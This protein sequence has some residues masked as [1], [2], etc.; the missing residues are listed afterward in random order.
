MTVFYQVFDS[1]KPADENG[2]PRLAGFG[3]ENSRWQNM[4]SARSYAQEWLGTT[5]QLPDDW[6]GSPID[7]SGYG[8]TIEIRKIE[9]ETRMEPMTFIQIEKCLDGIT[10]Y[11][12]TVVTVVGIGNQSDYKARF[13]GVGNDGHGDFCV[14]VRQ[15]DSF[16]VYG[17]HA[18]RIVR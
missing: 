9:E 15:E 2:F 10:K 1:G 4:L 3:W 5:C 16:M 6:D 12:D 18:S 14:Y 7:Y 8:D 13:L 17:V 11:V